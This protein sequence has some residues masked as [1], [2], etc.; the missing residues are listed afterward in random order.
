MDQQTSRDGNHS[1]IRSQNPVADPA[2]PVQPTNTR[3]TH[4]TIDETTVASA[5]LK[6]EAQVRIV[7]TIGTL[8]IYDREVREAVYQH[9]ELFSMPLHERARPREGDVQVGTAAR[10]SSGN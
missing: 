1:I 10:S 9:S 7:A 6:G 4:I 3:V 5:S 2:R 8:P